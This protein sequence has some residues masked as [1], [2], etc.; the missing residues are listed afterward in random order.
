MLT[1]LDGA[2]YFG[3]YNHMCDRCGFFDLGKMSPP[4]NDR[5]ESIYNGGGAP[6][7][8]Y[9]WT[10][11]WQPVGPGIGVNLGVNYTGGFANIIDAIQV[12]S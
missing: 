9:N 3:K 2:Y 12:C 6:L 8:P 10:G 5:I 1:I 4:K 11:S 7:Q